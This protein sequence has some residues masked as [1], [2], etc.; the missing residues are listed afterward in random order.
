MAEHDVR[1]EQAAVTEAYGRNGRM[2]C[3]G[4]AVD[5]ADT[6]VMGP[7]IRLSPLTSRGG[8]GRCHIYIPVADIPTV[9]RALLAAGGYP[10]PLEDR[11]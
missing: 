9:I 4:L 1:W 2:R 11:V 5:A 7:T 3:T 8:V 6:D 10:P